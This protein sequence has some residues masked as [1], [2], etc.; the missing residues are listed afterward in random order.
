MQ[1]FPSVVTIFHTFT[2]FLIRGVTD[3]SL[4]MIP[5]LRQIDGRRRRAAVRTFDLE[6]CRV[7]HLGRRVRGD[8]G[9]VARKRGAQMRDAE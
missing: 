9:E 3:P 8:T 4:S 5:V 1:N 7:P 2:G 6:I